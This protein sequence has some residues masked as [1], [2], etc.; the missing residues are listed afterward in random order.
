MLLGARVP[1]GSGRPE[2]CDG[3][4]STPRHSRA[5]FLSISC[6]GPLVAFQTGYQGGARPEVV[7]R[8]TTPS[9]DEGLGER[10]IREAR[11]L[12]RKS[13]RSCPPQTSAPEGSL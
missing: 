10:S 1:R 4:P 12:A 11:A 3:G 9:T 8:L 7:T 13:A 6:A 5:S 2:L